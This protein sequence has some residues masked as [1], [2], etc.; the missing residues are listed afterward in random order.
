MKRYALV[1]AYRVSGDFISFDR[2]FTMAKNH[3]DA[4]FSPEMKQLE[5]NLLSKG[6][7][8][9]N[10]FAFEIPEEVTP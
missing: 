10:N 6:Y 9:E 1:V 4:Y 5:D 8:L 2:G 7:S 3:G